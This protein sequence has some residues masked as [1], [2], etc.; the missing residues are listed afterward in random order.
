MNR[1]GNRIW[2]NVCMVD[3][4]SPVGKRSLTLWQMYKLLVENDELEQA[5]VVHRMAHTYGWGKKATFGHGR[6]RRTNH[7]AQRRFMA[8][9]RSL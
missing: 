2:K 9:R 8:R 4:E 5:A 1:K 6:R 7:E 3:N